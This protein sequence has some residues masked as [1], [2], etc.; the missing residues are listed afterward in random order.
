MYN[1]AH[2]YIY[3]EGIKKDINKTIDLLIRSAKQFKHSLILL[4]L[5]L[6][7]Q[8]DFKIQKIKQEIESH[9]EKESNLFTK[10]HQIQPFR[11]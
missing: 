9:I 3:S 4:C 2:I 11:K 6:I 10:I 5:V 8:C 1:L 7:K